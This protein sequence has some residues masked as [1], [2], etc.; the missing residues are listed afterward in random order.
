[1]NDP[2]PHSLY[3]TNKNDA[4]SYSLAHQKLKLFFPNTA[5]PFAREINPIIPL[6]Y[7]IGFGHHFCMEMAE[8]I[9]N[10]GKRPKYISTTNI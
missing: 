4:A 10:Q 9:S 1:M 7:K 5:P 8:M 6:Q 3:I 2:E